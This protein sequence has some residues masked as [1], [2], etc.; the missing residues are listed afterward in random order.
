MTGTLAPRARAYAWL[1]VLAGLVLVG[2]Y[3]VLV[4]TPIGQR[5]DDRSLLG[6]QIASLSARQQLTSYLHE[7]R[8]ST[9]VLAIVVLLVIGLLR[10]RLAT[11]LIAVLAVGGAVISAE[12][13][14]R[15]L[16]RRDLAPELNSYID[17]GNIETYPSGHATIAMSFALAVL[18]VSSPRARS[19]VVPFAMLWAVGV[20]MA[21]LAAGWHRPSD[22]IGGMALAMLFLAAATAIITYRYAQIHNTPLTVRWLFVS[23]LMALVI[24]MAALLLWF[25]RGDTASV[26]VGGAIPAFVFGEIAIA[27]TALAAVGLF[28]FLLRD[29]SF[30]QHTGSP[31]PRRRAHND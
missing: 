12:I 4:R 5:W 2:C 13:L 18:V 6:G 11:A 3:A 1:S 10:R 15:V 9:I 20:P 28:A 7:I 23:G 29:L 19:Y 8:I 17:N 22:L 24:A 31:D 30:D 25:T 26:Q 21:A 16:P 27:I 14:K